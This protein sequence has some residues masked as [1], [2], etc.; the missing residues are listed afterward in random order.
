[1]WSIDFMHDTLANGQSFRTF[2][3]VDDYNREGH[4][5]EVDFGLPSERITRCLDQVIEWRGK[6]KVI[7]FTPASAATRSDDSY[8][9]ITSGH[10]SIDAMCGPAP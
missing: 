9:E 5:I 10:L 3:V 1:M 6:A 7:R 4:G 8:Q 2:N